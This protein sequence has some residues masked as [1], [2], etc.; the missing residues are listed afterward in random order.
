MSSTLAP[1]YHFHSCKLKL[2]QHFALDIYGAT[3][4]Y[5]GASSAIEAAKFMIYVSMTLI[6]DGFMVRIHTSR[7]R[8]LSSFGAATC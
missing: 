6:G 3:L 7:E 4:G 2:L 1:Q 8:I 5:F